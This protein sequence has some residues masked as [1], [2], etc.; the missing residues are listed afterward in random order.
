M[1]RVWTGILC[2]ALGCAAEEEPA[3]TML[4]PC[5]TAS[6]FDSADL[7]AAFAAWA[8]DLVVSEGAGGFRRVRR[9][10]TPDGLVD[11]TVSEGIAYGLLIAA[12]MDDQPLFDDLWR[13]EQLWLDHHGLMNWY[14]DPTGTT[15]CPGDPP[16]STCGAATDADQDMAWALLVA[17]AKWGGQGALPERYRVYAE[18]QIAAIR[19]WEIDPTYFVPKPGDTW[20]GYLQ[21]NPS[22]FA[23]AYYRVFAEIDGDVE[24]WQSVIDASYAVIENARRAELGNLD[25]G[26]VPAWCDFEGV[27]NPPEAPAP[28]QLPDDAWQYDAARIP[29]RVGQDWCWYEEPRAQQ[30][31][32]RINGFYAGIGA[33]AI[34]DGYALD[35]TPRPDERSADPTASAVFIGCAGVGAMAEQGDH[36]LLDRAYQRVAGLDLLTRSRYYQRSWTVLSLL[37]MGGRMAALTTTSSP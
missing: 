2:T 6:P 21:T 33:D 3:I 26:L 23:P 22:Y 24:G 5:T 27:P 18:R 17:D 16:G 7:D 32:A 11:S 31:L 12:Y 13:Y 29:F 35:G 8:D 15:A 20:G 9:P 1:R 30:Y 34:V 36:T 25:N 14:V 37:M 19:K 28:G 4:G 10:D